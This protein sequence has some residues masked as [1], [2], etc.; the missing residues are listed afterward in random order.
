MKQHYLSRKCLSCICNLAHRISRFSLI[1]QIMILN[2]HRFVAL[3]L[4]LVLASCQNK[5][6]TCTGKQ[7]KHGPYGGR[8]FF[9][10]TANHQR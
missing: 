3:L 7:S 4:V 1:R 9:S 8:W 2:P 10:Y 6:N 5:K